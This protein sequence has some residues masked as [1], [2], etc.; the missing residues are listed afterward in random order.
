MIYAP[1][2]DWADMVIRQVSVFP[3]GKNDDLVD[4]VS[5]ALRHLRE[6]GM[7]TRAPERHA[8][9]E[10]MRRAPTQDPAPLYPA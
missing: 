5:M 2:K 3:K 9:I 1:D 8:E 4:T 6:L 10:E 7:M